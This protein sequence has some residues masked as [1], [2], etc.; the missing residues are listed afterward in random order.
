MDTKR[1]PKPNVYRAE[2][3]YQFVSKRIKNHEYNH[4]ILDIGE[5]N[6]VG[7]YITD[8]LLAIP[9]NLLVVISF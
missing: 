3:T 2:K 4:A 8:K 1:Q 9:M 6:F 5:P 7:K